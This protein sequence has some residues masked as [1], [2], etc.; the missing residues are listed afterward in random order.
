MNQT[1]DIFK[2]LAHHTRLQILFLLLQEEEVCVC[3]IVAILELPQSTASRHLGTLKNAG[4][5]AD[6]RD[7]TWVHYSLARGHSIIVDQLLETLGEHLWQTVEGAEQQQTLLRALQ[8]KDC[9]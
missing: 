7:G 4:L 5:I 9:A 6:R 1:A 8:K 3:R 2:A